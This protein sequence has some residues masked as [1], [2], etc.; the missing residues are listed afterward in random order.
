MGSAGAGQAGDCGTRWGLLSRE[1]GTS[2]GKAR[3]EERTWAER[4]PGK[5]ARVRALEK[6]RR[7]A[8]T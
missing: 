6:A 3:K 5:K 7:E 4:R 2:M 8:R 1:V